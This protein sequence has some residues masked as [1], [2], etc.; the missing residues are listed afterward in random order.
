MLIEIKNFGPIDYLKI[1][2]EKDLHLIYGKNAIGKSY[3]I[4]CVYSLLKNLKSE[5]VEFNESIKSSIDLSSIS[6][7]DFKKE[8]K[9]N[10]KIPVIKSSSAL[11][12][13]TT[14]TLSEYIKDDFLK[15]FYASL[16]NTFSSVKNLKNR[17]NDKEFELI[18][19]LSESK[20]IN[21]ILICS[22]EFEELTASV[23]LKN[24]ELELVKNN[25]GEIKFIVL[26]KKLE[27][28]VQ[29]K[30][31][32]E[33]VHKLHLFAYREL[34]D[35]YKEVNREMKEIYFLPASRSGL[36]QAL[37]SFAP[38]VA[39]LSQNR[40]LLNNKK[41]E[42]PALSEPVSDYFL[43]LSTINK[44]IVNKEYE[45]FANSIEETILKGY[46]DFNE[47]TKKMTYKPK[48]LNIE[49]NLSEASS[50]VAELSPLVLYLRHIINH[51]F[52]NRNTSWIDVFRDKNKKGD[53]ILFIE[54]PEAHLHPEIQVE[55]MKVFADLSKHN[56]KIFITSHSNYMFN[57][58]NNLIL[59]KKI[60][61]DKIAVY[62][63]IQK[64]NGTVQNPEM[65]V[66]EDGIYDENF[67]ET[68]EKL[69]E[70]RMRIL[71]EAQ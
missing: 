22:N 70:E 18:I 64:E 58:L 4:Y 1:D 65:V 21:K 14:K 66:N 62:H 50:M 27:T 67:Q 56:L 59:D 26:N 51:K 12:D 63:L 39:E 36:Y 25:T 38:I 16:V 17:F 45:V 34:R 32:L 46:V 47:D 52:A 37:N 23:E 29:A 9:S 49:L 48:G 60:D 10:G 30:T 55:L 13:F 35:F 3:A 24:K 43:D 41:I 6:A 31:N 61:K 5:Y 28:I 11:N 53:D 20:T 71:E 19:T 40:F 33:L 68:S 2:I 15:G 44:K 8:L 7:E 42:L 54:E 69:Y 57:E